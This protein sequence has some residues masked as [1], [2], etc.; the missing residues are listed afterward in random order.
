MLIPKLGFIFLISKGAGFL[1]SWTISRVLKRLR[2]QSSGNGREATWLGS[3]HA[4]TDCCVG[5]GWGCQA[6]GEVAPWYLSQD[7]RVAV[8]GQGVLSEFL[9]SRCMSSVLNPQ[10]RPAGVNSGNEGGVR[11]L[12]GFLQL[13][14]WDGLFGC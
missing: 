5:P 14:L 1:F 3:L 13:G 12:C 2:R 4:P 9:T 7:H 11:R 10:D 8:A 6:A